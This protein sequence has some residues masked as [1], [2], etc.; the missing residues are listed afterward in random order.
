MKNFIDVDGYVFDEHDC[1]RIKEIVEEQKKLD[2]QNESEEDTLVI[3]PRILKYVQRNHSKNQII[4]DNTKGVLTRSKV[5]AEVNLCLFFEI[6]LKTVS[7]AY[8]DEHWKEAMKELL[9][10]EKNHTWELVPRSANKN[11]IG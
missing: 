2:E 10:I 7:E 5:V 3:T 9:Q 1:A 4:G 8:K 6:E 11:I